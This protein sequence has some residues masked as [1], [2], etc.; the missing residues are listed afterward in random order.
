MGNCFGYNKKIVVRKLVPNNEG[1]L[2]SDLNEVFE[3]N[4]AR[5]SGGEAYPMYFW[6]T[7]EHEKHFYVAID[8]TQSPSK[9]V[10]Y[11]V[12]SSNKLYWGDIEGIQNYALKEKQERL[13]LVLSI[14]VSKSHEN[15]GIG[16]MLMNHLIDAI[17]IDTSRC[18]FPLI[19]EARMSNT[20]A[21]NLYHKCG[22]VD[23][24]LLDGY[25]HEPDEDAQF[26]VL[27][28]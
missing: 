13:T 24:C 9:I 12:A 1:V 25:Y 2:T 26:M 19:L 11:V 17:K 3:I 28:F 7:L 4:H 18:Q 22:F 10:G 20:H 21:K 23:K 14:A 6:E 27:E 8:N 16:K 15:K 5:F